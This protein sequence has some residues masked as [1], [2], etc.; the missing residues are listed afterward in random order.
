MNRI[1]SVAVLSLIAVFAHSQEIDDLFR[2]GWGV[3]PLVDIIIGPQTPVDPIILQNPWSK[4]I[5]IVAF[6]ENG[7]AREYH[8]PPSGV[9]QVEPALWSE[10]ENEH[11]LEL[12]V[13]TR[14]YDGQP[15]EETWYL[16]MINE[17]DLLL[18]SKYQ[19]QAPRGNVVVGVHILRPWEIPDI[20]N[21]N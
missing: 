14:S 3:F 19:F 6:H 2:N 15:I 7:V 8:L 9:W 21:D 16:S 1:C 5:Y 20:E 17:V 10:V 13:L 18:T 4:P 11:L 12:S